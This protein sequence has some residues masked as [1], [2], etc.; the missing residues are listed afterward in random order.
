VLQRAFGRLV[1]VVAIVL[2]LYFVITHYHG[3]P[4][5]CDAAGSGIAHADTGSCP[6][7]VQGLA[8][9]SS[10]ARQR[11]Q[12]LAGQPET[13]GKLY[14][15]GLV[16]GFQVR[17]FS[18]GYNAD[19]TRADQAIADAGI[20]PAGRSLNVAAHVEVQAAAF[21]RA[22]GVTYAVLVINKLGGV[23]GVETADQPF[24]CN[25]VIPGILPKGSTL[26]VWSPVEVQGQ[27]TSLKF[28]GVAAQ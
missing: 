8:E 7:T 20:V 16:G 19:A 3:G 4:S 5:G 9:D 14:S 28:E 25:A 17:T 21:M 13:A 18:S 10:W 27:R 12:S 23:C 26:V 15:P 6:A 2:A 24:T 1:L 11:I 22:E